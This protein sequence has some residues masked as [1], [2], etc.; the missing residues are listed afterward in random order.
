M[1]YKDQTK[2]ATLIVVTEA[3]VMHHH[4]SNWLYDTF[5]LLRSMTSILLLLC[6][7]NEI[8]V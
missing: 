1:Y 6:K 8:I 7:K 5:C 2:F 3:S 4:R